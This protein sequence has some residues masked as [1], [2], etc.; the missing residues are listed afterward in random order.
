M[1][2]ERTVK[3]GDKKLTDVYGVSKTDS[4]YTCYCHHFDKNGQHCV[5]KKISSDDAKQ[6]DGVFYAKVSG[7]IGNFFGVSSLSLSCGKKKTGHRP[8]NASNC[9]YIAEGKG[10]P[11][12]VA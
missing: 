6:C 1:S 5:T 8:C 4:K 3:L 10:C 9:P 7:A 12:T 2:C 11:Y